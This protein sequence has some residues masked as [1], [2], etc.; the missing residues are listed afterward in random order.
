VVKGMEDMCKINKE[1]S[2]EQNLDVAVGNMP[3]S[4]NTLDHEFW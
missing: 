3:F 1:G 4:D 2:A